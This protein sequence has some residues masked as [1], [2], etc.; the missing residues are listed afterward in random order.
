MGRSWQLE[1]LDRLLPEFKFL[2][3]AKRKK[4]LAEKV[5]KEEKLN[6]SE[7]QEIYF[8]L[9]GEN[10]PPGKR[11]GRPTE[12]ERNFYLA[13]DY[14][15]EM[16]KEG[17]KTPLA[18]LKSDLSKKY[19]LGVR[20]GTEDKE[21]DRENTFYAALESGRQQMRCFAEEIIRRAKDGRLSDPSRARSLAERFLNWLDDFE[22]KTEHLKKSK[23]LQ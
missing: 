23:L 7:K 17:R 4:E 2:E 6:K 1:F 12:Q 13:Y 14:L 20:K 3:E 16:A 8:A 11:R 15:R 18:K 10:P 9:T 22:R 19:K 5:W 21:S